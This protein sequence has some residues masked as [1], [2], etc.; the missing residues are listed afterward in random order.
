VRN[1]AKVD[2][3]IANAQALLA[4]TDGVPGAFDPWLWQ[5]VDGRQLQNQWRTMDEVPTETSVSRELS[6]NLRAAGFTF[7]GPTISYAFMQSAG[8]VNDHLTACFRH[9]EVARLDQ[10]T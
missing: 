2:A 5:H 4:L 8:L 10:M 1:R 6:R 7:V 9:P 3:F